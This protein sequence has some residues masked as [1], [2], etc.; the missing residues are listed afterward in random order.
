LSSAAQGNSDILRD[1]EALME[2]MFDT[3]GKRF[4]VRSEARAAAGEVFRACGLALPP[5]LRSA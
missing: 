5:T 3:D 4:I 2:T 1:L